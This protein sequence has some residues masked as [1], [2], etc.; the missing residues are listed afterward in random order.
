MKNH[1]I[2][3]TC[4]SRVKR[5]TKRSYCHCLIVRNEKCCL[6]KRTGCRFNGAESSWPVSAYYTR[7]W[8]SPEL[9][10][11]SSPTHELRALTHSLTYLLTYLLSYRT[12]TRRRGW[13]CWYG[14]VRFRNRVFWEAFGEAWRPIDDPIQ[15]LTELRVR[16]LAGRCTFGTLTRFS[17][18]ER[19]TYPATGFRKSISSRNWWSSRDEVLIK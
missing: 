19:A 8:R 5:A 12:C 6:E 4:F 3:S 7:G 14:A 10:G 13:N 9:R 1:E 2:K 16:L 17:I 18:V 15:R 11:G